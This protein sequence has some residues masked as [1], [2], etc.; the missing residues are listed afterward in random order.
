MKKRLAQLSA[1]FF[2]LNVE[3]ETF[4][5]RNGSRL[6]ETLGISGLKIRNDTNRAHNARGFK[7]HS[8][9]SAATLLAATVEDAR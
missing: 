8:Q 4:V 5:D 9:H 2:Q 7:H 1:L 3:A 6:V